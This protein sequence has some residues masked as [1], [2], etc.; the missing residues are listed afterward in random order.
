MFARSLAG[1]WLGSQAVRA[2]IVLGITFMSPM[3][4]AQVGWSVDAGVASTDNAALTDTGELKDT[5][6]SVGGTLS[7]ERRTERLEVGLEG[8]GRYQTFL[9]NT[10]EDD[11]IGQAT[12][13]LRLVLAPERLSWMLEDNYG[14][15]ATNQFEPVT[16]ENRQNVNTLTTGPDLRLGLGG[17]TALIL[18]GRYGDTRYESSDQ[19]N[20]SNWGGAATLERRTSPTAA[21]TLVLS[22][23]RNEYDAPS[24]ALYDH[25]S[26]YASWQATTSRQSLSLSAGANRVGTAGNRHTHPLLRMDWQRRVA[27]SWTLDVNLVSEYQNTGQQFSDRLQANAVD[28]GLVGIAATPAAASRGD[29]SFTFERARTRLQFGG[30]YSKLDFVGNDGN[31]ED[32]WSVSANVTRRIRPRLEGFLRVRVLRRDYEN[33]LHPGNRERTGELGFDWGLGRSTFLELAYQYRDADSPQSIY[34]YQANLL[35]ATIS[36]RR[37]E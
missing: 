12:G 30:G 15:M 17:R 23:Y 28:A 18:S 21:V 22:H 31:D 4:L 27:P 16:P 34:R 13:A 14:Q 33:A 26:V 7:L 25:Q 1:T 11:F 10:F 29:V 8:E 32:G 20:T 35:S 6:A 36:Y 2:H 24:A 5:L 9:N 3:A 19:I 37:N